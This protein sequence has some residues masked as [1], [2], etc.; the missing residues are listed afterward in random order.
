MLS[1]TTL[2]VGVIIQAGHG[3]RPLSKAAE[4][5]TRVP[6]TVADPMVVMAPS[7]KIA[8][9]R[10]NKHVL[11]LCTRSNGDVSTFHS[12]FEYHPHDS[13]QRDHHIED[14]SEDIIELKAIG[15]VDST[16][17]YLCVDRLTFHQASVPVD[18]RIHPQLWQNMIG[19]MIPRACIPR[20]ILPLE[21]NEKPYE[22]VLPLQNTNVV[23]VCGYKMVAET[24]HTSIVYNQWEYTFGSDTDGTGHET[25]AFLPWNEAAK[26]YEQ[27][28]TCKAATFVYPL[29]FDG[30]TC[31]TKLFFNNEHPDTRYDFF[32]KNCNT[33]VLSLLQCVGADPK[34]LDEFTPLLRVSQ[35]LPQLF[36]DVASSLYKM[37]EQLCDGPP[38]A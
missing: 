34:V 38:R 7:V 10:V 23:Y 31:S 6:G 13:D 26:A 11:Y 14:H 35:Q 18:I 9:A 29:R 2:L 4:Q 33:Y 22:V 28:P 8:K 36:Q 1:A 24:Y 5:V 19:E 37:K 20:L 17:Y 16:N 32:K 30:C 21:N 3:V 27:N 12:G 15:F 25:Y